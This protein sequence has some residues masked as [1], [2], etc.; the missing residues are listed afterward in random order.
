MCKGKGCVQT[1]STGSFLPNGAGRISEWV[2]GAEGRGLHGREFWGWARAMGRPGI[3]WWGGEMLW[4]S[5]KTLL[6]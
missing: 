1:S 4:R 2:G 6:S 3:K 5:R